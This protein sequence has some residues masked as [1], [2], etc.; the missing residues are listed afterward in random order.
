MFLLGVLVHCIH[1]F[2]VTFSMFLK[3]ANWGLPLAAI[4]DLGRSEEII[5]GTMTGTMMAYS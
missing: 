4:T 5:S 2:L 1:V 3:V